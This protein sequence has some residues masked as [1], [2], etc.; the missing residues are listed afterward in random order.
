MTIENKDAVTITI[1]DIKDLAIRYLTKLSYGQGVM[2]MVSDMYPKDMVVTLKGKIF[3]KR[4]DL[5]ASY[6]SRSLPTDNFSYPDYKNEIKTLK[7]FENNL[8]ENFNNDAI[9]Y[10][11][12][13]D[14]VL[15]QIR[16]IILWN[17]AALAHSLNI[18][19]RH[20]RQTLDM[21]TDVLIYNI[22]GIESEDSNR[23]DR[24]LEYSRNYT[25][26]PAVKDFLDKSGLN[27]LIKGE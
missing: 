6:D 7:A 2:K 25:N 12:S 21:V 3:D 10:L 8:D 1:E 23:K 18:P 24:L 16:Y 20:N 27:I 15:L 4:M 19:H 14:K 13:I 26:V 5:K 17:V 9:V 11:S 22:T